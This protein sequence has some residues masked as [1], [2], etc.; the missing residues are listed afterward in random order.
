MW[1]KLTSTDIYEIKLS[2]GK[3]RAKRQ[4]ERKIMPRYD[5]GR[6]QIRRPQKDDDISCKN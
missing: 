4:K 3:A 5:W 1:Y 2:Q 6:K